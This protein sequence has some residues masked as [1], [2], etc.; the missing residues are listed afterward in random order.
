VELTAIGQ[1][2]REYASF[3]EVFE[4]ALAQEERVTAQINNLYELAFVSKEFAP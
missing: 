1:P 2:K 3:G 4:T